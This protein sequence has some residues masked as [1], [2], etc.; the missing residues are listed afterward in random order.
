MVVLHVSVSKPKL[1][2]FNA[3][4]VIYNC[5]IIKSRCLVITEAIFSSYRYLYEK[6]LWMISLY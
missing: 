4:N 3:H 6:T 5:I 2:F 1:A